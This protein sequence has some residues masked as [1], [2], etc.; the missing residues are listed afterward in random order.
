MDEFT[1]HCAELLAPLGT[2]RTRRMF[3][4]QGIYVDELFIALI[5]SEQLYLKADVETKPEFEAAG[6]LPFRYLKDGEWMPMSYFQPPEETLDSPALM[7]PWARLALQAALRAQAAKSTK[8][9]KRRT[10][11]SAQLPRS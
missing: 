8:A 2:V 9:L 6:C 7:L 5:A 10:G 3:G 1:H 11:P 4:G